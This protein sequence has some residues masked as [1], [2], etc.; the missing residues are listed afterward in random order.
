MHIHCEGAGSPTVVLDAGLMDFSTLWTKVQAHTATFTRVC[1]YDRAGLGWS[2][3][4]PASEPD[5]DAVADLDALLRAAGVEAPYVLAGHSYGG[6]NVRR[7]AQRYPDRVLGLVLVDAAGSDQLQRMPEL[8]AAMHAMERQFRSLAFMKDLGL[9]AL[10][11]GSIPDRGLPDESAR[12]YRAVLAASGYFRAAL[13]ELRLARS[14]L[15]MP[16]TDSGVL[17]GL[18]V[19]V[20]SRGTAAPTPFR[21]AAENA[22]VEKEWQR[23]QRELLALSS[24]TIHFVASGSDHDIHLKRPDLVVRAI[25]LLV[26]EPD[27]AHP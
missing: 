21:S 12:R 10:T 27:S 4:R 1:S 7:F 24:R 20:I 6:V 17:G 9:L 5:A 26:G 11:P 2:D 23:M 18:P 13:G 16:Q 19:I 22:R 15:S 14:S 25:R 3:P 8:A